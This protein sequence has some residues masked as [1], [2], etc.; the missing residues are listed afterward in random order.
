MFCGPQ[1][2]DAMNPTV[3]PPVVRQFVPCLGVTCDTTVTPNRCTLDGPFFALRPPEVGYPF[4]AERVW[5][6]CQLSDATGTH[7][8]DL[9]LSFDLD[10]R[11]RHVRSFRVFMGDD[12]LAVRHYA[13][14]LDR[15]PFR[16]P[17]IYE[18]MLRCNAD[19]RA[20]AVV[21]LEDV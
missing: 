7:T 13:V 1:R 18:L 12:K 20:R 19:I 14:P 6:F 17:G 16:R 8:F 15:V 21:R 9:D 3:V 10:S 5:V 11:I 2:A 4:L